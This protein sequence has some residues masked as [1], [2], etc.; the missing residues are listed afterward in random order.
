MKRNSFTL[1]LIG[2]SLA[3]IAVLAYRAVIAQVPS[4]DWSLKIPPEA[5]KAGVISK[6]DGTTFGSPLVTFLNTG[7]VGIGTQTP[8]G[9]LDVLGGISIGTYAGVTAPPSNGLIISGNVGIGVPTPSQKLDV[10]GNLN[11]T[12]N[13]KG[14]G[15]CFGSDCKTAWSQI[16]SPWKEVT[17]EYTVTGPSCSGNQFYWNYLTVSLPRFT[18]DIDVRLVRTTG[19]WGT[20]KQ[21]AIIQ[22]MG[23]NASGNYIRL[24]YDG[25]RCVPDASYGVSGVT[26]STAYG[27]SYYQKP[28]LPGSSY[29]TVYVQLATWCYYSGGTP[30]S[31]KFNVNYFA[32][33]P[34]KF[35]YSSDTISP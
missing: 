33:V 19:P 6:D 1:I 31:A 15:M 27:T 26:C 2:F 13:L 28:P 35:P 5:G 4:Y 24:G 30:V 29:Q 16:T 20:V 14:S 9:K 32:P 3:I 21:S 23:Y 17:K 18:T 25:S 12:G 22:V 10:A 34:M 7:S 8:K 11:V